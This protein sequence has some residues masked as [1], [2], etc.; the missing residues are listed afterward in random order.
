MQSIFL[1]NY[2]IIKVWEW[3]FFHTNLGKPKNNLFLRLYLFN[4][5]EVVIGK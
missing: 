3:G 1:L 5:K 2:Q 4:R